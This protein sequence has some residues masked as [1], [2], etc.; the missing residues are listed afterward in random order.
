MNPGSAL[1]IDT[2]DQEL[3][4]YISSFEE[5]TRKQA[6]RDDAAF[7]SYAQRAFWNYSNQWA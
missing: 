2:L 5:V 7:L 6:R 3:E 1:I 4:E